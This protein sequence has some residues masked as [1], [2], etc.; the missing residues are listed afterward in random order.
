[1]SSLKIVVVIPA[2]CLALAG[3]AAANRQPIVAGAVDTVGVAVSGGVQDQGANLTLGYKGAKFAVVP[4]NNEAGDLLALQDGTDRQ[5]HFSVFA[6]LGV[7]AKGGA[8]SGVAV[9]QVLAV[10]PAAEIWAAGRSRL[11]QEQARAAGFIR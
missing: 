10:G 8:A 3:C 4:T 2:I 7:D 9:E 6:M 5:K 11:T 1:M